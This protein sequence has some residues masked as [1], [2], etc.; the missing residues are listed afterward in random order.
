MAHE[1]PG[2]PG[3]RFHV[4]QIAKTGEGHT[5]QAV[6]G[7]RRYV[8][9]R[10]YRIYFQVGKTGLPVYTAGVKPTDATMQEAQRMIDGMRNPRLLDIPCMECLVPANCQAKGG[11]MWPNQNGQ[12]THGNGSRKVSRAVK[13]VRRS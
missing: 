4:M 1:K 6:D 3:F 9:H 10:R 13:R 2:Q 7:C 5:R 11:C 12:D 8:R